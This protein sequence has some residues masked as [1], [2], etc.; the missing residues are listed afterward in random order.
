[1]ATSDTLAP[2]LGFYAGCSKDIKQLESELS[3]ARTEHASTRAA[4]YTAKQAAVE[5]ERQRAASEAQHKQ[6]QVRWRC[7]LGFAGA[8]QY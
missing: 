7:L 6:S 5:F 4:L 1:M 3:D 8:S 2:R